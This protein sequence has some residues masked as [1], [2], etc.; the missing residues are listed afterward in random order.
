MHAEGPVRQVAEI[1]VVGKLAERP[2]RQHVVP[3]RI[4]L[5]SRHVVRH[6]VQQDGE[7]MGARAVH[8]IGPGGFAAEV[9][10]DPRGIRDIVS[11]QTTGNRLQ[12][13]REIYMA[14][15]QIG[16]VRQH[17]LRLRQGESGMQLQPIAGDP[18]TAHDRA[19]RRS[20]RRD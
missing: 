13:G 16:Q 15:A 4:V 12:A 5:R 2:M 17:L 18:F 6:D 7:L 8:E 1:E 10:A 19:R 11:M 3:P 20:A 14:D 9:F